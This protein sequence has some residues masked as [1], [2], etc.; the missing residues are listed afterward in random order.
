MTHSKR[1]VFEVIGGILCVSVGIFGSSMIKTEGK[2]APGIINMKPAKYESEKIAV[3]NLDAGV[4]K[5][6]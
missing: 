5:K 4:E 1:I 6:E 3:V 2:I